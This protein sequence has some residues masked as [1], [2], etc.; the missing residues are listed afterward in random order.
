MKASIRFRGQI[1]LMDPLPQNQCEIG[2][3]SSLV[4]LQLAYVVQSCQ[5]SK[6]KYLKRDHPLCSYY[7]FLGHI[8]DKCFIFH[9]YLLENKKIKSSHLTNMM[10]LIVGNSQDIE[11]S[12]FLDFIY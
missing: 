9:G 2:Q 11:S 7:G 8:K 3:D 10:N 5:G 12:D 6:Q 4:D 1:L